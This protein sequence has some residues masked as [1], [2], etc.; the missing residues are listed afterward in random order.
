VSVMAVSEPVSTT[1]TFQFVGIRPAGLAP[2]RV[3]FA[4]TSHPGKVRQ[5]NEDH[6][7]ITRLGRSFQ[8][9]STN[10]P[11]GA[12]PEA[13]EEVA[14]GMVVADGM[15]GMAAGERASQL[16]IRTGVDLVL[17]SPT[18]TT[19]VDEQA[20]RHL[21]E[22]LRS[23]FH[24][25]DSVVVG[26]ASADRELTG[27]GT[28]LTVAYIIDATAFIVHVGDSRAYLFR[29]GELHQLTRD[30]TMAEDLVR[31]G[32]IKAEES[33]RH[34]QRHVLTNYVGGPYSGVEPEVRTVELEG[35]DFLLLCSDGLTEMVRDD[36]IGQVLGSGRAI[37][38][39]AR[40]LIELALEAGGRDNVTVVL[41]RFEI[42]EGA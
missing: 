29:Q 35:G 5:N 40:A 38:E 9:V 13:V 32:R 28:T 20:A 37:N 4:A 42:P 14:Y 10:M 41:A 23:Y 31:S 34:P 2:I 21:I 15:G 8:A 25:V 17:N 26:Q 16:A 24:E 33:H 11:D 36:Q 12:L 18:W 3:E 19:R 6:F 39:A 22:R 7:L 27:M 1:E 30:H